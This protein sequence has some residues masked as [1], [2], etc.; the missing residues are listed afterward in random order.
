MEIPVLYQ[1][2]HLS[3]IGNSDSSHFMEVVRVKNTLKAA[4]TLL[5]RMRIRSDSTENS[6]SATAIIIAV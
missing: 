5:L 3:L 6:V 1:R 2:R 4:I